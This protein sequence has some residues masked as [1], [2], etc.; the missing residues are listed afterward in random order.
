MWQWPSETQAGLTRKDFL[1]STN[2]RAERRKQFRDSSLHYFEVDGRP[3]ALSPPKYT[4]RRPRL[5]GYEPSFNLNF[6]ARSV[7]VNDGTQPETGQ[8]RLT[9]AEYHPGPQDPDEASITEQAEGVQSQHPRKSSIIGTR[10]VIQ[11]V[12]HHL[13]LRR[14]IPQWLKKSFPILSVDLYILYLSHTHTKYVHLYVFYTNIFNK[15]TDV[16]RKCM[17]LSS[18]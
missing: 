12:L 3:L 17:R 13:D 6:K 14:I 11:L 4:H 18:P 1:H 10:E 8:W 16:I 2:H 7:L 9:L 5:I 15:I